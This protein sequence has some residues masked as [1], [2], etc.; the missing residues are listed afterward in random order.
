[1]E[2][3]MIRGNLEMKKIIILLVLCCYIYHLL[4][5]GKINLFIHPRLLIP[6]RICLVFLVLLLLVQLMTTFSKKE[7]SHKS[8]LIII[9]PVILAIIIN[10][11]G[12]NSQTTSNKGIALSQKNSVEY[13]N[14][15]SSDLLVNENNFAL[16]T[17]DILCSAP[18]KFEGRKITI[19]GFVYKNNNMPKNQFYIARLMMVCCA[20]DTELTGLLSCSDK[21]ASL[22]NDEWVT[23][24]GTLATTSKKS[25][26]GNLETM[27]IIMVSSIA[28]AE[29]SKNPYIYPA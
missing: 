5:S 4:S 8:S 7:E 21:G 23:I 22:K 20:A 15:N 17:G 14:I 6:M 1:M 9:F 19:T 2:D 3:K 29:K 24:S 13:S 28:P 18:N 26:A 16:V 25:S 27:P 10:P 11:Q 12:L